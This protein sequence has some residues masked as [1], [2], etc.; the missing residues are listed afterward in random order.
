[1]A[2]DV[3]NGVQNDCYRSKI[4]VADS[5]T[6]DD[7]RVGQEFS[8]GQMGQRD[9]PVAQVLNVQVASFNNDLDATLD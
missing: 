1:M 2:V 8:G 4:R 6:V 7:V 3:V 5:E 9:G